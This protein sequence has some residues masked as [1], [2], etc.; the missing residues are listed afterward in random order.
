MIVTHELAIGIDLGATKIATA[1][2]TQQGEVIAAQRQP[3]NPANG[4][5]TVFR[6]MADTINE[7]LTQRPNSIAGVGIGTPGVVNPNTG[8][9]YNAVNLG[10]QEVSLVNELQA[11]LKVGIP[12]YIQNDANAEALG[13]VYFGAGQGYKNLVYL[14]FG[15]GLGSGVIINGQLLVGDAFNASEIGHISLD[16]NGRPCTCGLSGCA[17]TIVSGPGLLAITNEYL[18][19]N[20]YKTRLQEGPGLTTITVVE[21]AYDGDLLARA[22]FAKIA[23]TLGVVIAIYAAVLNPACIIIGGGLGRA[24]FDLL[25]PGIK[26]ELQ[27]RVRKARYQNLQIVPS[28]LTSSAIGASCLVWYHKK[29]LQSPDC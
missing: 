15:T 12:V 7:W 21:A 24:T 17:E 10:W 8:I 4:K 14:G 6:Q 1:L 9:V 22:V 16:P 27:R 5:E 2:V 19:L 3:T 18:K 11:R 28:Q 29:I 20:T 23:Q 25:L 26:T 13:E